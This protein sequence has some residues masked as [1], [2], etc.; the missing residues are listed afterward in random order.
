MGGGSLLDFFYPVGTYYETSDANF[1]PNTSWGGEWVEDTKGRVLV[2][3][4][5]NGQFKTVNQVMG[6]ETNTLTVDNLPSHYHTYRKSSTSTNGTALSVQQIPSHSHLITRTG[7]VGS[8]GYG[9]LYGD[10][11][12]GDAG[13]STQSTGEGKTHLHSITLSNANSGSIGNG[14]VINNVQPSK[15]CVRWHR[16]S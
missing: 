1:N 16:I 15:V 11:K 14:D 12:N 8:G 4:S 3:R 5:D 2:S 9:S 7:S 13:F 10:S 6:S